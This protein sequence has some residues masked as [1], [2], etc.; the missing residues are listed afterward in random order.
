MA[1]IGTFTTTPDGG[2]TGAINTFSLHVKS[3]Q[4]R[5]NESQNPN[6]PDY[7]IFA[8]ATELGAAWKQVSKDNR[9]YISVKLDDPSFP[10]EIKA[11]LVEGDDGYSLVWSRE[12][13][14]RKPRRARKIEA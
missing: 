2:F 7:R 3:A 12:R 5:V 6:A 14:V 1:N 13:K 4:F 10:D 8:G 9:D 11:I